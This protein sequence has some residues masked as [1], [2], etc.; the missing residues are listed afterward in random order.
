MVSTRGIFIYVFSK[1]DKEGKCQ[2]F[3]PSHRQSS[4]KIAV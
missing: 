2:R 4:K 3:N 1:I